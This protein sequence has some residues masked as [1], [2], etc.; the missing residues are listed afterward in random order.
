MHRNFK[1]SKLQ[2]RAG[3]KKKKKK[4]KKKEEEEEEEER[5]SQKPLKF[6]YTNF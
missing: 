6:D 2:N 1:I 3:V 5:K 4:K